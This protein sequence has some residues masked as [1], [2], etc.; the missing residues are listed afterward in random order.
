MPLGK[1]RLNIAMA[2]AQPAKDRQWANQ[3]NCRFRIADAK[4]RRTM[5]IGSCLNCVARQGDCVQKNVASVASVASFQFPIGNIGI[6]NWQHS[7]IGNI[8]KERRRRS[9]G[10]FIVIRGIPAY[11]LTLC[12]GGGRGRP[13]RRASGDRRSVPEP[14]SWPRPTHPSCRRPW[15]SCRRT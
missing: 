7:H 14:A 4:R 10:F 1:R 8:K 3:G 9:G 2:A 5:R 12:G 6:G 11:Q 15:T 13:G